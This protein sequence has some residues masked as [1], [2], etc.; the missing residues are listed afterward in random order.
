MQDTNKNENLDN[1]T[2]A[3]KDSEN[4]AVESDFEEPTDQEPSSEEPS[5]D[6]TENILSDTI[7]ANEKKKK[8]ASRGVKEIFEW[9]EMIVV[10]FCVVVLAFT[11]VARPAVVVGESMLTTL[12]DGETLIISP[13]ATDYEYK[14]IVVFQIPE[15]IG[16]V[17]GDAIVKRVIATEGQWVD[18]N[19]TTWEVYVSD[20]QEGLATATPLD[21]SY[22]N[23]KPGGLGAAIDFPLQVPDGCLFVMGDNRSESWD[24]R[25]FGCI[26]EEYVMGKV[27]F[28]LFPINKFG[29][30]G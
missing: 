26:R 9:V 28:R 11:F 30:V 10:S 15:N 22:V 4:E 19:L 18:I 2:E 3:I 5:E 23:K 16:K 6:E 13:M 14:D 27:M 21:E 20:T 25:S 8:K 24:S 1:E 12:L 29:S 7:A 17:H